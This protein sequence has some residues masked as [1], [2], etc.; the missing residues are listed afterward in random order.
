MKWSEYLGMTRRERRGTILLL[1]L[2]ALVMAT[3][4][5]V[6]RCAPPAS[7]ELSDS[8]IERFEQ[9][10]DSLAP[11]VEEPKRVKPHAPATK[12]DRTLPKK[13][14]PPPRQRHL[15]PVPEI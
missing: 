4:V 11:T 12:R 15:E 2:I 9:E 1:A 5:I 7:V 6:Q 13:P 3:T 8:D 10:I 14:A